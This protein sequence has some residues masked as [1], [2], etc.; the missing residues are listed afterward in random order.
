M[1]CPKCEEGLITSVVLKKSRQPAYL[2]DF[3]E[4][5]WLE[6]ET[7]TSTTGHPLNSGQDTEYTLEPAGVKDQENTSAEYPKS[8]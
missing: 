6:G 3:C 8:R 4:T 1:K 7:I 2:C 5:L